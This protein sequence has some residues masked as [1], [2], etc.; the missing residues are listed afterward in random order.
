MEAILYGDSAEVRARLHKKVED[1]LDT[2]HLREIIERNALA[3]DHLD[4]SKVYHIKE[5]MEKAEALKLQPF[6][7]Y[8]FFQ[9][10]FS[11]QGGQLK[12]REP[13]RF[14]I[15]HVPAAIRSRD[16]VIGSGNPVLRRYQRICFQKDRTR[17]EGK[18]LADLLAPGHPLMDSTLDL[19]QEQY[20]NLLKQGAVLVDRVDEGNAPHVLYIIDH[21]IR[22][23][24]VERSGKQRLISRRMQFVLIDEVGNVSRGGHAPYLDYDE[25]SPEEMGIINNVLDEPWLK[26]NMET[27]ALSHAVNTMVPDHFEEVK[28]R[29]LRAVDATLAA[30]HERL[31]KEINYWSH[32][33]QKLLLEVD[34]GRQ[35]RMQPEN[36]R[37]RAEDLTERLQQRTAELEAQR[38]VAS[39]TPNIV[40]GALI[41]P[42]GFL[43][44]KSGKNIPL[45]SVD[46]KARARIEKMAMGAVMATEKGMGHVPHDISSEKHGW[47]I[48]S[49]TGKGEVR[50]IEVKG[51]FKG[52]TQITVTKNEILASLNQPERFVLAIV[53]VD[54]DATEGPYYLREP[55]DQEPGFGVTSINYDLNELLSKAH[56]PQ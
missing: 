12:N 23:G 55:F 4:A 41:I 20:R 33:Y 8:S 37:R 13:G 16:R 45:W 54:G 38:H 17:I 5:E 7:I 27:A 18:P 3:A 24:G 2:A 31:T 28:E 42:K 11:R 47:D 9:E 6:F 32:R 29:R 56:N 40:G 21:T 52:A 43:D 10:A 22:D 49:H 46:P 50:F 30:V 35:P 19:I 44:Q 26:R 48:T 36:A 25:A 34:A 1:V 51:R 39:N 53:L 14:E 15:T